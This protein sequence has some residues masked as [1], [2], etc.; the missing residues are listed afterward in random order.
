MFIDADLVSLTK[1]TNLNSTQPTIVGSL[2]K[3][4]SLNFLHN[5]PS[6]S[7]RDKAEASKILS[8][9][10]NKMFYLYTL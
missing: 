5:E 7:I 8:K 6:F 2:Q 1:I 4:N 3:N 9:L 10:K